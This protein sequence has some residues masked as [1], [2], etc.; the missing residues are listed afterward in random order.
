MSKNDEK[1]VIFQTLRSSRKT[2]VGT[3]L[4]I[5]PTR[6]GNL[7]FTLAPQVAMDERGLPRF[8]YQNSQKFGFSD[9]EASRIALAIS[10][11]L[12]NPHEVELNFPH[13]AS[14]TPKNIF[15]KFSMY[16]GV[17]QGSL[18][19]KPQNGNFISIFLN[20]DEL[21]VIKINLESQINLYSK[22]SMIE[23]VD[24]RLFKESF[25]KN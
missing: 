4:Q 16:N 17:L 2:G 15:L 19:V 21:N 7:I 8:D 14:Q 13:M 3:C 23:D 1:F 11:Q 20:E 25:N 5:A 18:S 10:R 12:M 9:I 24:T 22:K 6:N